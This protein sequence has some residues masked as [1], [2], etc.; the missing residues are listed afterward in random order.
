MPFNLLKRYNQ[1][2][3][4]AA[5]N[6]QQRRN[7][8]R[9]VFNRDIQDNNGFNFDGKNINPVATQGDQMDLLFTHLTTV[10]VN[11]NNG[12]EFDLERSERL[13]WIKYLIERN[14]EENILVF[15]VN[16]GK[17]YRTYIFD[18]DENYVI[19]LEPY[20]NE[21]EYYLLTAYHLKGRNVQ[22]MQKKY[23]RRLPEIL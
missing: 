20:R 10:I 4:I 21:Q 18:Q 15:S 22:K 23:M 19:V 5:M 2:L 8:L 14:R 3:E 17:S 16:E 1:L 11:K 13:H 6:R 12:R 9:G 7:S